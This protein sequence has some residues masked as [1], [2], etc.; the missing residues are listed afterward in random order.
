MCGI[1]GVMG[2]GGDAVLRRMCEAMRHR[3]PDDEGLYTDAQASVGMVRLSIID[4]AG[5]HQPM[6]DERQRYQLVFNGEIYN[7][8]ALRTQLEARGHRLATQ[9]DTEVIVH[10]YEDDQERCVEQLDGDFA[11]AIWDRE[12]RRLFLARD[13]LGVKPLYY[14]QQGAQFAFASELKALLHVPGLSKDVDWRALE[15]YLTLLYVPSPSSILRDVR[16]L[17]PATWLSVDGDTVQT[18]RYWTLPSPA[19]PPQ[20]IEE[21]QE[22]IRARFES[23]VQARMMSDVPL[24]AFL[25]GGVDSSAVVAYLSRHSSQRVQTFSLGFDAPYRSYNE[26]PSARLV[27]E[28]F[29]TDHHE[30]LVKPDLAASLPEVVWHLDEPLADSSALLTFLISR[31]AKQAVTVALTGIGGDELFG[32]YPRYLGFWASLAYER[33]PQPV[34]WAAASLARHLPESRTSRNPIGRLTRFLDG[35]LQP[36]DQ[37]Y[38]SWV[39]HLDAASRR[40]LYTDSLSEACASASPQET[41]LFE[42]DDQHGEPFDHIN[43]WDLTTYLPDDLLMLGDKMSMAHGLEIR[44]PFCDHRLVE[45]AA[46]IPLRVR[47]RGWRLKGFLKDALRGVVPEAVL[48]K[49]K[50]GFMVPLS[51]WLRDE[52]DPLCRDLLSPARLRRR[53]WFRPETVEQMITAHRS[54]Q[55]HLAHP[56]YALMVLELWCQRYLD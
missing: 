1:A 38:L 20:R 15:T 8:Q 13:R 42:R 7:Y 19:L 21:L 18:H 27:A 6:T 26:L 41:G 35:S 23:S 11:L 10:L 56:L 44:V 31:Q 24:G 2:I 37:R 16:K 46:S 9:S 39:S 5:G 22:T 30:C 3:G 48:R 17:P 29:H 53:G 32:G 25:S 12:A 40:A 4:L 52:L 28:A 43:R 49:S 33:V 14:W 50:Q 45:A 51:H 54:G 47:M 36:C 55:A 34:R